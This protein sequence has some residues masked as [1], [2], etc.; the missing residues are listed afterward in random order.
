M[1]RSCDGPSRRR[2]QL[3]LAVQHGKVLSFVLGERGRRGRSGVGICGP[4]PKTWMWGCPSLSSP[5]I[6]RSGHSCSMNS[7]GARAVHHHFQC[8]WRHTNYHIMISCLRINWFWSVDV[9]RCRNCPCFDTSPVLCYMMK[10]SFIPVMSHQLW[11]HD[12]LYDDFENS[13]SEKFRYHF[14]SVGST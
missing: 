3:S 12:G 13:I 11:R 8:W 2:G 4:V 6:H 14:L 9:N 5:P 7:F 1:S 10:H